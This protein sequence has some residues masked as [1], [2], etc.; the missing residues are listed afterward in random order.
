[1]TPVAAL[2]C[3]TNST[4]LLVV[5]DEGRPL[6]RRMR[7]TRLGQGVDATGVLRDDAIERTLEVLREYRAAMDASASARDGSR[8]RPPRATRAN[9]AAFLD[10]ATEV[11]GLT[12]E[13]LE[14]RGGGPALLRRSDGGPRRPARRRWSSSTSAAA[15]PSSSRASTA[16]SSAHSMQIGLRA[17]D[18]ARPR[19][20]P[21]DARRRCRGRGARRRRDR[22]GVRAPRRRSGDPTRRDASSGLAGTVSTLAM[23]DLA[24]AVYDEAAVHHHWL[25][26]EAIRR[27]ARRRSPPRRSRS[28][29]AVPGMVPGREDVIVAG[30]VILERVVDRL[31]ADGL[32]HLRARHPR[33]ARPQ[34]AGAVTCGDARRRRPARRTDAGG[35]RR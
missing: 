17:A 7:I 33:R 32:P 25:S 9:G 19:G 31:G 27:V 23:I 15:R 24:L 16:R 20:D 35:G 1:M 3:G 14:R 34:R 13:L 5:D 8:R 30:V 29:G 4:R 18:R 28:A 10:A 2:D 11:T 21:P 26:L 22:R 12:A 6:D